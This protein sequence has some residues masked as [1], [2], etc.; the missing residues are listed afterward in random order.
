MTRHTMLTTPAEAMDAVAAGKRVEFQDENGEWVPDD[1]AGSPAGLARWEHRFACGFRARVVEDEDG[2]G[3]APAILQALAQFDPGMCADALAAAIPTPTPP[4]LTD[5]DLGVLRKLASSLGFGDTHCVLVR[6]IAAL[7]PPQPSPVQG[8]GDAVERLLAYWDSREDA[9]EADAEITDDTLVREFCL[10]K[11]AIY[12]VVQGDLRA[13]LAAAQPGG[14]FVV[15]PVEPTPEMVSAM[16]GS[17]AVDDEGEFPALL[18]L[19]GFSGDNKS[20]TVARAAYA[21][22]LAAA[23]KQSQEGG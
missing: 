9:C 14:G 2:Y 15:V 23:P 21:A 22:A 6:A 12:R 18:D 8:D 4:G 7:T 10:G 1:W 11:A 17:K 3:K 5:A 20:R 16:L 13:A 19:L